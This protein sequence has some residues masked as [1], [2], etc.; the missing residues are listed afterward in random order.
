[1]IESIAAALGGAA[2]VIALLEYGARRWIAARD[3]YFVWAPWSRTRLELD[4]TALPDLP[5]TV[6]LEI[7]GFGER[8]DPLPRD[9]NGLYRVLVAGGSAAEC[10]MLDQPVSW[11]GRLQSLLN[12]PSSLRKLGAKRVH[13]G[14]IARSLAPCDILLE[15]FEHVSPRYSKLDLVLLMVGASD[16]VGWLEAATPPTLSA[17]RIIYDDYFDEHP[18]RPY[19]LAP[20][21]WALRRLLAAGQR[22]IQRPERVRVRA[23]ARFHEL[24]RRRREAQ[25]W[26]DST[27]D[28]K[29]MLEHFERYFSRLIEAARAKGARVIVVR[30]PWFDKDYTPEEE[31]V[32]WSFCVGRPYTEPTTRYY[33][34]DVVRRLMTL[35]DQR[36]TEVAES[37]GVEHLDLMPHLDRSLATYYDFLHFTPQGAEHVAR[38]CAEQVLTG[39]P[40]GP[41]AAGADS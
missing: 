26:I 14:N 15:M 24:R 19:S 41:L 10:Y 30:Q 38:L 33:T 39:S 18:R 35:V 21:R 36:A 22:R 27:P 31:A 1:M 29:P 8:G 11:P 28:P 32:M 37:L 9:R 13:V 2:L 34:H 4:P 7:N 12:E 40:H 17:S 6:R 16:V 25:E 20:S 3:A 23:G 5:S